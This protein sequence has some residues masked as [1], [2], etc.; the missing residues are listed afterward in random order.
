MNDKKIFIGFI[1]IDSYNSYGF[2]TYV[3][4]LPSYDIILEDGKYSDKEKKTFL[5]IVKNASS[6][7]FNM[8]A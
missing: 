6:F 7:F 2:D 3:I 1:Y 8:H 4:E 5:E